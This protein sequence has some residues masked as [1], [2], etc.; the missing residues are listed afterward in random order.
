VPELIRK[1]RLSHDGNY[2]ASEV[3]LKFERRYS[4]ARKSGFKT[5]GYGNG[6]R[7]G[8]LGKPAVGTMGSRSMSMLRKPSDSDWRNR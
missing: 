2:Q 1:N 8:N 5:E 7:I 3:K 6:E 4:Y